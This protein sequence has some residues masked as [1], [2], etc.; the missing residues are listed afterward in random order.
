[1]RKIFV[2]LLLLLLT[3]CATKQQPPQYDRPV[4]ALVDT[5]VST[6]AINSAWLLPGQNYANPAADTEDRINHG[7]AVASTILG[8]ESAGVEGLAAGCCYVVPLVVADAD[9]SSVTPETLAKAIRDAV[10][11]YGADIINVSLGIKK[12]DKALRKAVEYAEKQ[13]VLVVAAAGNDG[14]EDLFYPAA[15]ETVLAVGSH[16]RNGRVSAFSQ[17]NGTVDL[18]APGED[19]WFAS[20]SGE[21]YGTRGTSYATGFV[22]A[23]A[24]ILLE[25]RPDLSP[26][27][28]RELLCTT[29]NGQNLDLDSALQYFREEKDSVS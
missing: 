14:N 29:A 11:V 20:N 1:M 15:Y 4:I 22:S 12:D 10:D 24:A 23:A 17:R 2:L 28:V 25:I 26:A 18:L 19:V 6:A 13:G 27:Q 5:G 9:Q 8:C 21:T 16:D 7:T 3:G